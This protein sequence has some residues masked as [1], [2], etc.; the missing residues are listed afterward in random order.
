MS[1][2]AM[3]ILALL[4]LLATPSGRSGP[5]LAAEL[6]V[7]ERTVRTDIERLRELGYPV[8]G[9]RGPGGGYRFGSGGRMPPLLLDDDEAVATAVGLRSTARL[10]GIGEAGGRALAKLEQMLPERLR[11]AV[12]AV[13]TSMEP[14]SENTGSDAEDPEVAPAALR[15]VAD[16]IHS[17][18]WLRFEHRG[19]PVLV[20]PYRLLSWQR[21]WYLV[22]RDP[23]ADEWASYRLDHLELRMPTRRPFEPVPFPHGDFAAFAVR[24]AA[25]SGWDVHV[26][27]RVDASAEAVLAR[28]NPAVGAVEAV[29]ATHSV[30][31][32][33]GDS[34]HTVAAYVGMLGMD[35]TVESPAEL[36]PLFREIADRY[37]RAVGQDPSPR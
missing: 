13:S 7:S 18:H 26:R 21:R 31:L 34:L 15:A 25:H 1:D 30:L 22:A 17:R 2:S 20:E 35:F 14:A 11:P 6:G 19:R 23:E 10:P 27:L 8:D 3:R 4:G 12:E 29:D 9:A 5:E 36:V 33:G 37:R 28:I 16:A 32:T 24:Q